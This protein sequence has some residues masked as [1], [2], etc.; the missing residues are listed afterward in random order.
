MAVTVAAI[1]T[2]T[3][4]A[5]TP[6][7]E[8]RECA[9]NPSTRPPSPFKAM[10]R[11]AR[12][13]INRQMACGIEVILYFENGNLVIL[14]VHNIVIMGFLGLRISEHIWLF[15]A[16]HMHGNCG[17]LGFPGIDMLSSLASKM[18]ESFLVV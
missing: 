6:P 11:E 9:I 12:K 8:S 17:F 3:G 16:L 2:G 4:S 15:Y 7:A 5:S 10:A 14:G 1:R 18:R 13:I